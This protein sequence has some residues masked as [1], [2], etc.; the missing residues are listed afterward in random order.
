[1]GYERYGLRGSTVF[2]NEAVPDHYCLVR[3]V[4]GFL[5]LLSMHKIG[6]VLQPGSSSARQNYLLRINPVHLAS[7]TQQK[8]QIVEL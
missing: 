5:V 1:M 3:G 4:T 7:F 8:Q 2:R 6:V